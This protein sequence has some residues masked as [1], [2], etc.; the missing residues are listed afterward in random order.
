MIR[1]VLRPAITAA[2]GA[3]LALLIALP[4]AP[5]RA[6]T[7]TSHGV[8]AFGSLNYPADFPHF[9]YVNPD[10]PKGGSVR[11]RSTF[12]ARTFDSLNPYILKGEPA[13]EIGLLV[14][15]TLMV[16]AFDET[17]AV[18]GLIAESITYP[19]DRS[20][21]EFTLRPEA[22]FA[23]GSPVTAED[24]VFSLDILKAEGAPTYEITYGAIEAAEV[25]GPGKVKF[26]F[27]E[28]ASTRDLP[29]LAASVPV[30]SKAYWEGREFAESTLDAPIG[31]GPY[32]IGDVKPGTS[33]T[34]ELR[35][36][37]WGRDLPVNKGRWNFGELRYEY[38][39]DSTAAFEAFKGGEYD[40]HEEFFS[41]LWATA[42]DFPALEK[43]WVKRDTLP[44]GRPAGTQ[45]YWFN[46]RRPIFADPQVRQAIGL[47]FDFEWSNRTL[48]YGIYSRTESFFQGSPLAATGEPAEEEAVLLS[49]Y[50]A[51]LPASVMTD[52]ALVPAKTDGSG[53]I[54]RQLKAA[55]AL[56]DAA[57]WKVGADGL[58][59]NAAGE[60]MTIEFLDDS[61]A[62]ERITGPYI[63]NLRQ[64]GVDA[65]LRT[66]DSAQYQ[67][68]TKNYDFDITI[69]RMPIQ[70]TPGVELLNLF[71]S[72]AAEAPSTLNLAGVANPAIDGLIEAIVGAKDADA[73][74]TAVSALD[75]A[76]RTLHIWV[77]QW[78]KGTHT[79]AYWDM[80]DRPATKPPFSRAIIDTWWIDP[81]K[82]AALREARGR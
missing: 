22:K 21:A 20:W 44:D 62:F 14:F 48:F 28:G 63:K 58:R 64:L 37:Y 45:G 43:S 57:G 53:R 65:S 75:R 1:R 2:A 34:Y 30:M 61:P 8:S 24:V 59:R 51:D 36:D 19:E 79:I 82:L 68:R 10:A 54:R 5:L 16:R 7:V 80:F 17:D 35:D 46:T 47:V 13:I 15:E 71:G 56:L 25:T 38:F 9:S 66:I 31:S 26:T 27:Q 29:M 69:A 55:G 49:S 4:G 18:Y 50:A 76:L 42:Y 12:A 78:T 74:A 33:I 39:K 70:P 52:A 72:A 23:D 40:L 67:E 60:A 77:P 41:K 11:T 3:T 73:H 81:D 32:R 6:E